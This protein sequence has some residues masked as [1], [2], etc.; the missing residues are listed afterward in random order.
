MPK[1]KQ[2]LDE[3]LD[4]IN[5]EVQLQSD[6]LYTIQPSIPPSLHSG[7]SKSLSNFLDMPRNFQRTKQRA[8]S[9]HGRFGRY[10]CQMS[11]GSQQ[12]K[13]Y[14]PRKYKNEVNT[15]L[16]MRS[17][18]IM[19]LASQEPLD[20]RK[21]KVK[22][23]FRS[24]PYQL[25]KSKPVNLRLKNFYFEKKMS[26][27]TKMEIYRA[28]DPDNPDP[29]NDPLYGSKDFK[30]TKTLKFEYHGQNEEFYYAVNSSN[31]QISN[32]LKLIWQDEIEFS[33]KAPNQ[34]NT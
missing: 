6:G 27:G 25:L 17:R 31:S 20:K 4:K 11:H 8:I 12:I 21:E 9:I 5:T 13:L 29:E 33:P 10:V 18:T 32:V 16:R 30:E 23:L 1:K 7:I 15:P 28:V 26:E 19:Q 22:E 24:Y 3:F 2:S 14:E 34:P